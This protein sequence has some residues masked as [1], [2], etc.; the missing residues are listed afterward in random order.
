MDLDLFQT[1]KSTFKS[2]KNSL[3][4]LTLFYEDKKLL[5]SSRSLMSL[6]KWKWWSLDLQRKNT[7][8][9]QRKVSLKVLCKR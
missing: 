4:W 5:I 2:K 3:K 9:D 6:F 8:K 7:K 1:L